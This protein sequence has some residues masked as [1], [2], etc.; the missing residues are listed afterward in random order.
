[1]ETLSLPTMT[2]LLLMPSLSGLAET[3][4]RGE[5]WTVGGGFGYMGK[6]RPAVI[7]Q[8]ECESKRCPLHHTGQMLVHM[9]DGASGGDWS[10]RE[11]PT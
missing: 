1:M 9:R 6:P 11:F 5:I 8:D 2:K 7:I 3:V 4:R 10:M